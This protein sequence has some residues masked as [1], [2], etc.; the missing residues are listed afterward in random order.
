MSSFSRPGRL[1]LLLGTQRSKRPS[2]K[3]PV[4]R[5]RRLACPLPLQGG[6]QAFVRVRTVPLLGGVR[7]GL[8]IP[9][10][11]FALI[12]LLVVIAIIAILPRPLSLALARAQAA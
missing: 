10:H 1:P 2:S 4:F 12:E 9:M 5:S 11:A 8:M 6:E 3:P 7:G